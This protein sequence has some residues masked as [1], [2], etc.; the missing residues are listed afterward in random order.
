LDSN[1]KSRLFKTYALCIVTLLCLLPATGTNAQEIP[2]T[3]DTEYYDVLSSRSYLEGKREMEAAQRIIIKPDSVLE[4][5]CFN[6]MRI[7]AGALAGRFSDYG[8]V[9]GVRPPEFDGTDPPTRVYPNSLD[10]ALADTIQTS[11]VGFLDSFWHIY[12]GG[13]FAMAPNPLAGC[14]PMN[15]VWHASKCLNFNR[16]WWVRFEDFATRDIRVFPVPCDDTDR[17]TDI[18]DALDEAFPPPADP[19]DLGSMNIYTGYV[20]II[21]EC[22]ESEPI[23]TGITFELTE[24]DASGNRIVTPVD[25]AACVVPGCNYDGV[26]SCVAN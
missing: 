10:D 5:S 18:T 15:V 12:G 6:D 20:D 21:T 26:D 25:D 19:V 14:N 8:L 17:T 2:E 9:T 3:C 22:G 1:Q 7:E 23:L 4:Y 16:S 13:T 11:L 24:I